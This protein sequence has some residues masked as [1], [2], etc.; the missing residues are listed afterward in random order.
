MPLVYSA[1]NMNTRYIDDIHTMI[2]MKIF[3][4][5]K[6][7][8]TRLGDSVGVSLPN[9]YESMEGFPALIESAVDHGQI[10]F[11]VR[12][13]LEPAVKETVDELWRDL[14]L[15][16]SS[17]ADIGEMPWDDVTIEWEAHEAAE[18]PVPI[19]AEEVLEHRQIYRTRPVSW[20]KE[21]IRK[22]IHDTMTKLCEI[23][24]RRLGFKSKLFAMAFGDAVANKF[25]LIS[26]TYGTLD[27]ACE[28]FSEEFNK[29]DDDRYWPLTSKK[30][31][32]A[33]AAGYRKIRHLEDRPEV[34]EQER[35][36]VQQKWGF[37]LQSQ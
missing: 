13:D 1:L 16:F 17:I 4:T 18:G 37:P 25:S 32:D 27:V 7:H 9:E 15:L 12:P 20:E 14:R 31:R 34:F 5:A 2:S 11:M 36:R 3:D 33:V 22:S 29:V 26:C 30:A 10:V 23:A 24:S 6:V 28:I 19:S 8:I 21:D 35:A